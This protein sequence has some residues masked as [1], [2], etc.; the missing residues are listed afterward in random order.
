MKLGVLFFSVSVLEKLNKDKVY[1]IG[2]LVDH[3]V[4]RVTINYID[5]RLGSW[6]MFTKQIKEGEKIT[7][8]KK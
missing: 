3:H 7:K 8:Q 1:I 6:D 4:L 5:R 2:G